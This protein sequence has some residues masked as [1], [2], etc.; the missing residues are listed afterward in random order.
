MILSKSKI[1]EELNK[2]IFISPYND[3]NLNQASYD[4]TLGNTFK[5]YKDLTEVLSNEYIV[6]SANSKFLDAKKQNQTKEFEIKKDGFV[7][8]PG[9]GYLCHT[10][11]VINSNKY[12]TFIE[13]KSSI[14]RLFINVHFCAPIILP[15]FNGQIT[16]EI[17]CLHPVKI[18]PDMKIAQIYFMQSDGVIEKYNGKYTNNNST[19]PVG[20]MSF[21][22]FE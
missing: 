21:K 13:G 3:T 5:I 20:S 8:R 14:A 22:E 9:I 19:G 16:L 7:L 11:E 2:S 4:L 10:N 17:S 6:P 12:I 18:Y 15:H 1:K